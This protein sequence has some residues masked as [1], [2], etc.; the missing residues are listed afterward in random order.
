MKMMKMMN[1]I[2]I[3]MN[4]LKGWKQFE[5]N[6]PKW[7]QMYINELDLEEIGYKLQPFEVVEYITTFHDMDVYD[8]S[9]FWERCEKYDE[10]VLEFVDIDE[11]NLDEWQLDNDKVEDYIELYKSTKKYPI[12]VIGEQENGG[13]TIIDGLH[14]ANT[15]NELGLKKIKAYVGKNKK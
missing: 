8:D 10:F 7:K 2:K 4:Y 15:L 9:D 3:K 1:K 11:L 6:I 14:R 5:S 13:Y 12:I